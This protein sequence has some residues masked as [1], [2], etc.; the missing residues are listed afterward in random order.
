MVSVGVVVGFDSFL[1]DVAPSNS[2][3]T[4]QK[5]DDAKEIFIMTNFFKTLYFS[6]STTTENGGNFTFNVLPFKLA[7]LNAVG[8]ILLGFVK[9]L[10]S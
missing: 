10:K 9:E 6:S 1:Q 8:V 4:Q 5:A 7:P 3:I 2:N